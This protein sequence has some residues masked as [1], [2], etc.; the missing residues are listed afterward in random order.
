[1]V[2]KRQ[3]SQC[4]TYFIDS[5]AEIPASSAR[6]MICGIS[7]R[8]PAGF[9]KS[10]GRFDNCVISMCVFL[11][12]L[13]FEHLPG[14]MCLCPPGSSASTD[15]RFLYPRSKSR[16]RWDL[17]SFRVTSGT[18]FTEPAWWPAAP[19]CWVTLL[20]FGLFVKHQTIFEGQSQW[21]DVA[22]PAQGPPGTAGSPQR[23]A[24]LCVA[25]GPRK[26]RGPA[27]EE[28]SSLQYFLSIHCLGRG[29]LQ[30][31]RK[32]TSPAFLCIAVLR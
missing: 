13:F 23:R 27:P 16:Q 10:R 28:C 31:R 18:T 24:G 2:T 7:P 12:C 15:R 14:L 26:P 22:A 3:T 9:P 30:Y 21:G 1:M 29:E 4:L 11:E 17:P 5:K 19:N 8:M 25:Q 32:V 6:L 20:C